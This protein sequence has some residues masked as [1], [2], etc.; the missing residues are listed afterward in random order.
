MLSGNGGSFTQWFDGDQFASE[1]EENLY[2]PFASKDDWQVGSF[3][4]RSRMT[5]KDI[6]EFLKIPI[7]QKCLP[8]SFKT[9]KEL[10]A[11]VEI[12]PPGPQWKAKVI[13]YDAYPTKKPIVLYYRDALE[14]VEFLLKNPIIAKHLQLVPQKQYRNGKRIW[15]EWISGDA[16]WA[17]QEALPAGATLLGVIGTAD[18]TNISVMNGDRVAHPFLISL[19]NLDMEFQMKASNHTFMMTA[20]LPI[21]KFLCPQEIRGLMERRLY[22]HCLDIVCAPLKTAAADGHVM[23]TSTGARLQCHTPLAAFIADAPEAAD[24]ACVMGKTSH[25]TMASHATFDDPFRHPS[26]TGEVTWG[27]ICRVN[28][29]VDPW[30][31]ARYQ[32]V[33]KEFR[34]SGVHL[35]FWR[36]WSLSTDPSRF[37]TMEPLHTLHKGFFDHDFQWGQRILGD[38][39]IDFRLSV[40][41]PRIGFRHF[42]EGVTALKQL[43]GREH[44]ELERCFI[45]VIADAAPPLVVQALRA[46]IDFRFLLQ[47][48]EMDEETLARLHASLAEFHANKQHI[49][50]AGGREQAHFR[51]P[52]LEFMQSAVP[53]IHTEI[54]TPARTQ[55]NHRDYDPQ[56]VRYLD[57]SEKMRIFD[58]ATGLR[59]EE[60]EDNEADDEEGLYDEVAAAAGESGR[61]VRNLFHLALSHRI[62]YPNLECRI[63]T[64]SSTAFSLNRHPNLASISVDDAAALFHLPDLRPALGDYLARTNSGPYAAAIG[65]ARRSPPG[66]HLPFTHLKVWFSIRVQVKTPHKTNPRPLPAQ[67]LQ[68]QPPNE[69]WRHGRFDTVLLCND[70]AS[71]WPGQ[72]FRNGLQGHTIAQVR[73]IMRP[74]WDTE[75]APS[76]APYLMYA[77][78]FD[79][80]PQKG[81]GGRDPSTG[82][83][84]LKRATRSNGS[85]IGDVVDVRN[86][87]IP[88]E[89][90]ARFGKQ[91]D[92]R[93]APFNSLE[94]CTE[95]RLNKYST[96]ELFWILESVSL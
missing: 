30:D 36:D 6:D 77:Q 92:P 41:Q 54:K 88:A 35:P 48:P 57:R 74:L 45:A 10:R 7:V 62:R 93:F 95:V 51:I 29:Q 33:S 72:G 56:I 87:R 19:A 8:L 37:L 44:R 1:R 3:F 82:M 25:L 14:C 12:L 61:P 4:L 67:N 46:L 5:M 40:I 85:R 83:Y 55:T 94:C 96:K 52:K 39:E 31:V 58:L 27:D 24:I 68:A 49:I 79:I 50:A 84:L 32:K 71:A 80:I 22:H 91:A 34:L 18:K 81:L 47:A 42:K 69:E 76:I 20:L 70:Q 9:A 66:C 2:Y 23:S 60:S 11:R 78:R 17:M 75:A 15:K 43:G 16:A 64:T 26:R 28:T 53:G 59:E 90:I 21:P 13:K 63:F 89:L 65:G 73:L 86:I 38:E